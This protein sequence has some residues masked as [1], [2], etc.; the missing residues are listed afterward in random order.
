RK[1]EAVKRMIAYS[2]KVPQRWS[3]YNNLAKKT[4]GGIGIHAIVLDIDIGPVVQVQKLLNSV[5]F[6]RMKGYRKPLAAPELELMNLT[7]DSTGLDMVM[8][9]DEYRARVPTAN[10]FQRNGYERN[11][12]ARRTGVVANL[13]ADIDGKMN[14]AS[15]S[16]GAREL[17]AAF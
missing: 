6:A 5:L 14:R 11:P 4:A 3:D 17:A 7:G 9:P 1:I 2:H 8:M 12:V 10:F 15:Q 13:L 16:K